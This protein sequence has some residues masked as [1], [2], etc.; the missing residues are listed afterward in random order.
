MNIVSAW[1]IL[2]SKLITS[3]WQVSGLS[4]RD[5]PNTSACASR[6]PWQDIYRSAK[7]ELSRIPHMQPSILSRLEAS[8][9]MILNS[10]IEIRDT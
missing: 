7:E 6:L 3:C 4:E 2:F 9:R 1:F 10:K 5:Q 8:D